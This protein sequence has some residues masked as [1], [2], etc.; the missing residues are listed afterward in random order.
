MTSRTFTDSDYRDLLAFRDGLRQFLRW[1]DQQAAEAGLTPRQHQLLLAIRGHP[2]DE[3]ATVTDVAEHLLVKHHS[4]VELVDRA[5][6]A[7]LVERALDD[8]DRRIARLTL[9]PAGHAVLGR[10]TEAHLDELH[11][12]GPVVAQLTERRR[13][14]TAPS[15]QR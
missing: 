8:H 7:G 1:S 4:A 12:L 15:E 13:P 2:S 10:L 9:T 6:R 3:P 14:T 5:E 11:R